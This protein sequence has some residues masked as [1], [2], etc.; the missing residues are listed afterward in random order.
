MRGLF[1]CTFKFMLIC[2]KCGESSW[3][4]SKVGS[5]YVRA[6]CNNCGHLIPLLPNV[7]KKK[8]GQ[9]KFFYYR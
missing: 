1:F 3:K 4:F 2:S 8:K 7:K 6:V 5:G 9:N